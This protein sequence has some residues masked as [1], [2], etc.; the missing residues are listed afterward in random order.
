VEAA[1]RWAADGITVNALTPGR[2][3]TNLTRYLGAQPAPPAAFQAT[4]PSIAYKRVEQ[5]ASTSVLLAAAPPVE[6]VTGRSFEDNNEVEPE[7][8]G[9]RRGV[10]AYALDPAAAA[11]LWQI[12]IDMLAG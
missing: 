2:I 7:K 12:S 6:G 1:R 3:R 8:P 9:I 5:G 10:A 11:R 4:N